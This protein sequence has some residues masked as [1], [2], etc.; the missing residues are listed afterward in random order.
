MV[1][2]AIIAILASLLLPVLSRAKDR[3]QSAID[4]NNTRQIMLATQLYCG[5][6]DEYLPHPTWGVART[7]PDGWAYGTALMS[8]SAGATTAAKLE[9]QL[10]N[11]V[12]AFKAGQL[13]TYLGN[14]HKTLICPKDATESAGSKK[15]LYLQRPVKI[16]SYV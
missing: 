11:Q 3:A 6:H 5:D 8:K 10:S 2:I 16:T 15:A 1:V 12:E 13:A 4:F 14:A 9:A 7:D